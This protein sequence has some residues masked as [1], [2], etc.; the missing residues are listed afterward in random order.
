M[1]VSALALSSLGLP[2]GA[3]FELRPAGMTRV[4]VHHHSTGSHIESSGSMPLMQA[5][6][7]TRFVGKELS[8][9]ALW[10][11]VT[12]SSFTWAVLGGG[13]GERDHLSARFSS[14]PGVPGE[15]LLS[16]L[17]ERILRRTNDAFDLH[18]QVESAVP[19]LSGRSFISFQTTLQAEMVAAN[20]LP[21]EGSRSPDPPVGGVLQV[22]RDVVPAHL[23]HR[24]APA[25]PGFIAQ[26]AL[27][28]GLRVS[29]VLEVCWED[30]ELRHVPVS[31]WPL[32]VK[33]LHAQGKG[34][35]SLLI[36]AIKGTRVIK[37]F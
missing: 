32:H 29:V 27:K 34:G 36:C 31:R 30:A 24:L 17:P 16:S 7:I 13:P 22:R 9:L 5:R 26:A 10:S 11:A 23:G 19:A 4:P 8:F 25:L 15:N 12:A 2:P 6:I 28:P 20:L 37:L 21:G 14:K 3:A 18:W 35:S 1:P 33:E